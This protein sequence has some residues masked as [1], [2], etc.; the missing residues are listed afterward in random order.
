MF[1]LPTKSISILEPLDGEAAPQPQQRWAG[2]SVWSVSGGDVPSQ[3]RRGA[4]RG[5]VG[6]VVVEVNDEAEEDRRRSAAGRRAQQ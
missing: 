2:E 3:P 4:R 1:R 6:E 5:E